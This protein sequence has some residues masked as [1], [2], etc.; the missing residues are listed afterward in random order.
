[1][2]KNNGSSRKI[3]EQSAGQQQN[4]VVVPR[5]SVRQKIAMFE[6]K[7]NDQDFVEEEQYDLTPVVSSPTFRQKSVPSSP[8]YAVDPFEYSHEK[9][10]DDDIGEEHQLS[11]TR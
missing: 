11:P 1:M 7:M 4:Q 3:S 10:D 5:G 8:A 9:G 2:G 6:N